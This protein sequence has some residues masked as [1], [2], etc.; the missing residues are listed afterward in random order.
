MLARL[1]AVHGTP[2]WETPPRLCL[3]RR[4]AGPSSS[5][6][7]GGAYTLTLTEADGSTL[8]ATATVPAAPTPTPTTTAHTHTHTHT[9][10]YTSRSPNSHTYSDA[11]PVT[12]DFHGAARLL[13][14]R[15]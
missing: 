12:T 10:T 7:Q 15:I 5:L 4:E 9:H 2:Q 14:G 1:T 6:I 8:T 11:H 13:A 3:D